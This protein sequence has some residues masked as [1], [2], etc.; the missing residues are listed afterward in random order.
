MATEKK[1]TI[2]IAGA[3]YA[4]LAA[5]RTLAREKDVRV[6]LINKHAYHLLQFQLHEAAVNKIDIDTLALPMK[7]VLPPR[8]SSSS[9]RRSPG[10]I[11][12]LDRFTP[13]T[14]TST[15]IV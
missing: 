9:R 1:F 8:E 3:G 12:R 4:G 10:S 11:S 6:V 14:A 2:V 15:T 7:Y 5:A 13:I